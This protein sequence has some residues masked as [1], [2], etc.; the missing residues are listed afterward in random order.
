MSIAIDRGGIPTSDP[1]ASARFPREIPPEGGISPEGPGGGMAN[2]SVGDSASPISGWRLRSH[3]ALR[4]TGPVLAGV[5][6]RA[7]RTRRKLTADL[8]W[9]SAALSRAPGPPSERLT[10]LAVVT[11]FPS[12]CL[13]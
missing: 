1:R 12:S 3:V 2:L 13:G 4:V 5:T 8:D 9:L 6:V 11:P 7:A 10:L